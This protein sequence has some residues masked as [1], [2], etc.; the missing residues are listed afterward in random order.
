MQRTTLVT[1]AGNGNQN[2]YP[3]KAWNAFSVI[4]DPGNPSDI[5]V[6]YNIPI[7][8][9][10]T[11]SISNDVGCETEMSINITG[12]NCKYYVSFLTYA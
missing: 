8:A 2:V 4:A 3:G 6:N 10:G 1:L 12:T 5:I 9:G 7:P 11:Y